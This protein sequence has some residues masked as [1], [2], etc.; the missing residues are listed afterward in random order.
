M[1][2][3]AAKVKLV[4]D[5]CPVCAGSLGRATIK[6]M[7]DAAA[8]RGGQR[9]STTYKGTHKRLLWEGSKGH[10]WE[11]IPSSIKSGS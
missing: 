3:C 8:K 7:H 4:D 2:G 5:L 6:D 9:L 10:T 11:A 1:A